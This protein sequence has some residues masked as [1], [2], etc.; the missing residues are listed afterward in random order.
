MEEAPSGLHIAMYPWFALGHLIAFLQIG[1]KL[2]NKGHRISFF[3]PSKTQ[4]KLQPFNHFPNL[5]TFVPITVPH[6]DGLPLGAETTA[7]V[8]HPSQIPLI[9]TSMD[10]TEPEIASRLQDIKPEVIFY[11]LAYWVP[12]LAHPLGI[13]SVYF[14]AVS[15]V[16]MSYIQC[17]LWK[18]PGHYNLTRDDLLHPPPDFP[19]SSIK[20]H[21]HE[22]QYLASFGRMKF[23]GDI[24]F[25]ERIS[26]ALSQ[27]NAIALKSCREIEGPFIDYL[28]SIVERPILLPGTVNLEPLTTSLEER[29]ANWLSEFKSGS[30]IYCA[31][32]SECILTKNQFQE[33]LLG[34]ELSNLP[35]FVALK[36]PDGIDT[37]EAALPKGFK[38][39]IEGR[40]IVYG[41]WVQQQQILDHPSIGCFI[42][43]C[44]AES[45]SEA[46]VKKC[47]LVLFSRTTDQLFRARSMS[48]FLKVG[49]EIEKGEE[50]GVFSKESVCKAVKTVMDE[51]NESGKEIRANKE[52][53][54]ELLVDKD[55]EESYINN[56][57]H[58]LHSMV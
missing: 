36:P 46:V 11:D 23:G 14:T 55:L 6:V 26:N 37:V 10:R 30:V 20:L 19:C 3:I 2:A 7:D 24:T 58:S 40:G 22:A 15:A 57:I 21:A 32:G 38:Q 49:V 16:T 27:C 35:F 17:K 31:F 1:N 50:D 25:F 39:R 45:L 33:L 9:M 43:H 8:S 13:K 4:P 12:K 56:F 41:G 51:E 47:Q 53:L 44:G 34:L 52:K 48:K 18:F 29:W 28:E 54:R 5:I 42:T